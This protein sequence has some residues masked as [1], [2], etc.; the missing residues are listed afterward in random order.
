MDRFLLRMGA[1]LTKDP[2]AKKEMLTE[3]NHVRKENLANLIEKVKLFL[4]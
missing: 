4:H 2:V 1:R 3:Y